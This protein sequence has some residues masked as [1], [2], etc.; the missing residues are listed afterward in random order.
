MSLPSRHLTAILLAV[1][2]LS[3]AADAQRWQLRQV[4]GPRYRPG[5]VVVGFERA[6]MGPA[7]AKAQA[8]FGAQSYRA[9]ARL[10]A[11]VMRSAQATRDIH[12][13]CRAIEKIPGV[14]FCEP[15]YMRYVKLPAPN[16][17]AYN[18]IDTLVAPFDYDTEG[19]ATYYQ[20]TLR[21][22]NALAGWNIFPGAYYTSATRPANAIKVAVIDT[23]IDVD[24]VEFI[25][26][27]GAST[28]AAAGGQID[29][30]DGH[31]VQ[32]GTA[33]YDDDYGHGCAVSGV[34]AAATN[35]GGGSGGQGLAG[36]AYHAQIMPVKALDA[37]GSG[38]EADLANG[39][40][41]AV[42]HGAGVIN[43]SAGDYDYSL[44]EQAAVD[45]AWSHG[46]IVIAAAGND[47]NT[48]RL[49]P[50]ACAGVLA[51]G[52]TIWPDDSPASYSNSGEF[53]G[54][55]APGGD[56]SYVPLGFWLTWCL[57][58][59]TYVPMHEA[60]WEPGFHPYQYQA[61]TSLSSPHAAGLA[62][63]YASHFGITQ[64]TPGGVR[65]IFQAL[66][67][68]S[69]NVGGVAGW[70]PYWGWG[71]INVEQTLLDANN[72]GASVGCITGQ[73]RDV[74]GAPLANKLVQAK[75]AGTG[76]VAGSATSRADG[77]FR[78]VSLAPGN[79]DVTCTVTPNT[80][81]APNV[82]VVAS[83]DTP[84]TILSFAPTTNLP[85]SPPTTV[86]VS[87]TSPTSAENL[88]AAADGAVDPEG[89]PV[90]YEYKWEKSTD[91]GGAW[92]AGPTGATLLAAATTRGEMWRALARA[93]DGTN[94]SAWILSGNT[95]T[96]GNAPP[97]VTTA[98]VTPAS[99]TTETAQ[100]EAVVD[101]ASDPDGDALTYGYAWESSPDGATWS[102]G[103]T[104]Q[105]VGNELLAKDEHWRVK[106]RAYDGV[107]YSEWL[108]SDA[109]VIGNTAPSVPASCVIAPT[110]P[111]TDDDLT[112]TAT[113]A[114]DA[115]GD[116]VSYDYQWARSTDG[117]TTWEAWGYPG[118]TLSRTQTA[119]GDSWKARGRAYDGMTYGAWLESAPVQ[120][121]A[122]AS[123]PAGVS[124]VSVPLAPFAPDPAQL[125]F[126]L[127]GG[128]MRWN[129]QA[130]VY[131]PYEG[132]PGHYTW[133]EPAGDTPGKGY[134]G[135]FG[136][137]T[138]VA[139]AGRP[140]P[141]DQPV[142][143]AIDPGSEPDWV[144]IGCPRTAPVP[145]RVSGT[146][147]LRVRSGV[148]E[149]TL[150]EARVAGWCEDF[151][152]AYDATEGYQLVGDP[153]AIPAPDR[154]QM[155]PWQGYWFLA[156]R[157]CELIVPAMGPAAVAATSSMPA[158]SA[159][160]SMAL[161]ASIT[162]APRSTAVVGQ[163]GQARRIAAPPALAG[164]VQLT[165][166]GD[167]PPLAVALAAPDTTPTWTCTAQTG[168]SGAEVTLRWPDLSRVPRKYRPI[169]VDV[170]AGRRISMRTSSGYAFTSGPTS[171]AREL[172]V[173]MAGTEGLL[174]VSSV[175]AAS[176]GGGSVTVQLLLTSA[177]TV[178]VEVLNIAGRPVGTVC[179]GQ[180]YAA[181]LQSLSW[182]GLSRTG[183]RLPD[184]RYLLR[185]TARNG[186]GQ[187]AAGIGVL[188]MK[189]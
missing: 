85:P 84:H 170:A 147:A 133:F 39:I 59:N 162:G 128:W 83:S 75:V 51:V 43:I 144:Q 49:Y 115:D 183:T 165:V 119:L 18:E 148:Q 108:T 169:L 24:N 66:Q 111:G 4:T 179:R 161:V 137:V 98:H 106:V 69:D 46:T 134:W 118:V 154:A 129:P 88:T 36:L 141:D 124:L 1:L 76:T 29:A 166:T 131:V 95:V 114:T 17:P 96:I 182:N 22:I 132:D 23:G 121:Y 180:E 68:G 33:D 120:I 38:T 73:V 41:W 99:P 62:A 3:G 171:S 103:P 125:Q 34:I 78:V 189:R 5:E 113:G 77:T 16:D 160:W 122:R 20:W 174:A 48:T 172:R 97:T 89:L 181:G 44:L 167:G 100:L 168:A 27:G 40:I 139:V 107:A 177:A 26:A 19:T 90:S 126:E 91:G 145:W 71:R 136:A 127:P 9:L 50:A 185:V 188:Q 7:L 138:E 52:A 109:V 123:F 151:A 105:T 80:A 79:Y 32:T 130:G 92:T 110:T 55:A 178:D 163:A 13:L 112:A 67:R 70:N 87:P 47:G 101:E 72:R 45:Y 187:Q 184:G 37:T 175:T 102:A 155:D 152:W 81:T 25:N 164:A 2:C 12:G 35:N 153:S 149:M 135:R 159:D 57:M 8:D 56:V 173:E 63:L 104:E 15:N 116:A 143:I 58:P 54:I 74:D 142:V 31:N 140:L 94:F 61:G 82:P 157:A 156:H 64:A 86:S 65:R 10:D 60:G 93:S 53:V 186:E 42:D 158:A 30:A 146:G 11:H 117:G 150:A 176:A 21:Q 28:N 14:R 6:R